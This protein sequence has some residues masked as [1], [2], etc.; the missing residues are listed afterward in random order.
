MGFFSPSLLP[1]VRLYA[2]PLLN[3]V[4]SMDEETCFSL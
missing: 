1:R 4:G 3:T 2:S